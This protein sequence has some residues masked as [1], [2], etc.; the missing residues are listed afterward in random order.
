MPFKEAN[1]RIELLKS[2]DEVIRRIDKLNDL[3]LEA[4]AERK[5]YPV[6]RSYFENEPHCEQIKKGLDVVY[7][8]PVYSKIVEKIC[9][10]GDFDESNLEKAIEAE[11]KLEDLVW[12][13]ILIGKKVAEYKAPRGLPT[14]RKEREE[15][16][17]SY[18]RKESAKYSLNADAVEWIFRFIMEKNKDV[19]ECHRQ[20]NSGANSFEEVKSVKVGQ[21]KPYQEGD[22]GHV[23]EVR[24][25]FES[26]A[27]QL[28]EKTGDK[29]YTVVKQVADTTYQIT[30]L[31]E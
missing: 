23:E 9:K 10:E 12:E 1:E 17:I 3:I 20:G 22:G 24:K 7:W 4:L 31:K 6:G 8:H 16:V 15:A 27:K 5:K 19:Q 11:M 29:Y 25:W 21:V 14:T 26:E 2:F 30:I 28:S 13:R 18:V